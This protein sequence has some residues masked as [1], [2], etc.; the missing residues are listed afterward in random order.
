MAPGHQ[1]HIPTGGGDTNKMMHMDIETLVQV[2]T[3]GSIATLLAMS[4]LLIR[5]VFIGVIRL[6]LNKR[7]PSPLVHS[8]KRPGC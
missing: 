7:R 3:T 5:R 4:Y 1:V 8:E 2:T 6:C